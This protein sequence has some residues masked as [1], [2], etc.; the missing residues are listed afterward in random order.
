MLSQEEYNRKQVFIAEI[1]NINSG[2]AEK[3]LIKMLIHF[4]KK[5][6]LYMV[7]LREQNLRDGTTRSVSRCFH[8]SY[9]SYFS[10][11][12]WCLLYLPFHVSKLWQCKQLK[13]GARD[14]LHKRML[15]AV[16]CLGDLT[17]YAM[18]YFS[19][20]EQEP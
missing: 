18:T 11:R 9:K 4:R 20:M 19:F 3:G 10:V 1:G 6:F 7:A 14:T 16:L 17:A 8:M 13:N 2:T 5:E 12:L 15:F